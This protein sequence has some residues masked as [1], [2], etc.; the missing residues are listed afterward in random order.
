MRDESTAPVSQSA[1]LH[2]Y[3]YPAD[4]ARLVQDRWSSMRAPSMGVTTSSNAKMIEEFFSACY[5]ASL[6][7]EEERPVTFRAILA[8]PTLFDPEGSPPES[9]QRL[10]FGRTFA[11]RPGELRR[12]SVAADPART[13][14]GVHEDG[15]GGLQI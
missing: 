3:A 13:L 2:G 4:L 12:L 11:F 15:D 7:R 8:D 6:L 10:D 5:Q 9:L 1:K 14:I